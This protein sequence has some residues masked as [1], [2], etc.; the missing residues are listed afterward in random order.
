MAKT[1]SLLEMFQKGIIS[2]EEFVR[3]TRRKK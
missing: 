3:L 2:K 1:K